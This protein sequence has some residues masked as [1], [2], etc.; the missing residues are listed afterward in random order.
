[1][2]VS[3]VC[4]VATLALGIASAGVLGLL[5]AGALAVWAPRYSPY[6]TRAAMARVAAAE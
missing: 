2:V 5:A 4:G 6:A 3:I 1:V